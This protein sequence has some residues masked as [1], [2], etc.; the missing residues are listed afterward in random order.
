MLAHEGGW[1]DDPSDPGGE[2]NFGWSMRAIEREGFSPQ[3]LGLF[4]LRPGCLRGLT[5]ETAR[6]LYRRCF[7]DRYRYGE[8]ERQDVATKVFDCSVNMGPSQA[9]RLAQ[10]AASVCGA[11]LDADGL[12]GDRSIQALNRVD[13]Q[14]WLRAMRSQMEARYHEIVRRTPDRA[15]FLKGWL[16]RA[17]WTRVHPY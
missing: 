3:D 16:R 8:I 1:S 6:Q 13:P 5:A 2:T 12:L 9:H 7:W 10:L 4:D 11:V 17:A 15:R 14:L